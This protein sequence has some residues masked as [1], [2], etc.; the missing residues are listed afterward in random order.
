MQ[1][2]DISQRNE[3]TTKQ[4]SLLDFSAGADSRY[5]PSAQC[6]GPRRGAR[7]PEGKKGPTFWHIFDFSFASFYR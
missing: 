7:A 4:M 5:F 6:W 2:S 1:N 3:R